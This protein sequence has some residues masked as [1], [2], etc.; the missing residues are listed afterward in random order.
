MVRIRADQLRIY[1][2]FAKMP[3]DSGRQRMT[4]LGEFAIDSA[5]LDILRRSR[6]LPYSPM[7][8]GN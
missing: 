5:T 2:R 7:G 1:R 3:G 8:A 4:S 6:F